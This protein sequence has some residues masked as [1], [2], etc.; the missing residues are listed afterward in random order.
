MASFQHENTTLLTCIYWYRSVWFSLCDRPPWSWLSTQQSDRIILWEHYGNNIRLP[1]HYS[2]AGGKPS[3][4]WYGPPGR[5]VLAIHSYHPV[6]KITSD[7]IINPSSTGPVLPV[8]QPHTH[9]QSMCIYGAKKHIS[10]RQTHRHSHTH[11]LRN[12]V[13]HRK[14]PNHTGSVIKENISSRLSCFISLIR[15]PDKCS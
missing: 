13:C 4:K 2:M 10:S 8:I 7:S 6:L 3:D 11:T 15:L 12:T 9:M 1:K 14:M 5:A